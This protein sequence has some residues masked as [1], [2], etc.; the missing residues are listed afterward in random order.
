VEAAARMFELVGAKVSVMAASGNI[1]PSGTVVL[2][3]IGPA[4]RLHAVYKV[5]QNLMEYSGGI[6]NR[7]AK[8]V[9]EVRRVSS[10]AQVL[11]TRKHMPGAKRLSLAA[12]L[13]GGAKIHRLGLSDSILFFDHHYVL[14]GGLKGLASCLGEV[15]RNYPEKKIAVE[16]GSALGA[17]L[18][19]QAGADVIQCE[20]FSLED[21]K[22]AAAACKD[23]NPDLIILAAGGL[24]AENAA[25]FAA[26]GADGLVTSWPYFGEPQDIKMTF[27]GES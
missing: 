1:V 22:N 12:A 18:M 14:L 13:A 3:A 9:S 5:S 6:A 26:A 10:I 20:R 11:V 15:K 17:N 21:L 16:V 24:K 8:M 25:S 7:A 27:K 19:A 4:D 2:E 23:L